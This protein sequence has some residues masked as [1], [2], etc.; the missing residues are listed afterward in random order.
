VQQILKDTEKWNLFPRTYHT[1]HCSS[2]IFNIFMAYI[3]CNSSS[4]GSP[5]F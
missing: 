3:Y 2:C 4:F 1:N 5:N